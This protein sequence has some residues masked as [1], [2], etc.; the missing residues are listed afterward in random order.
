MVGLVGPSL[1]PGRNTV[2]AVTKQRDQPSPTGLMQVG[3]DQNSH[4]MP[5]GAGQTSG[6]NLS[7]MCVSE[8]LIKC[9]LAS[10]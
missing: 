1:R 4:H 3:I 8:S 6:E 5:P 2:M 7:R 10:I 9:W